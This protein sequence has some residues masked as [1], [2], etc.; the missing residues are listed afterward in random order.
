MSQ[1]KAVFKEKILEGIDELPEDKLKNVLDFISTLRNKD[2]DKD[3]PILSV[4]GCLSGKGLSAEEI[5][6]D[7]Y[8][9]HHK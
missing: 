9:T 3:D 7:L 4:V 5:E 8:R 1:S 6:E 2:T